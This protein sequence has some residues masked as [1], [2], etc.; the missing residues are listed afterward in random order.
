MVI[1]L[2]G[3][4]SYE[5]Q[6]VLNG[7]I[8]DFIDTYGDFGIERLDGEEA[9]FNRLQEAVTSLPFLTDKK[10]V[11]LHAPSKNKPFL[12]KAVETLK[13]AAI[14]SDII[15][16]EPKLDKRLAYYKFL[17]TNTDFRIYDT[18]D[19]NSLAQWLVAAAKERS[20]TLSLSDARYLVERVG[21]NQQ[22]V[23]SELEKLLLFSA[24]ISQQTIDLLTEETPQSTIFQLLE[25]AFAGN[26]RRALELYDEQRAMKVEPPQIIAML[27]WQLHI[28]AIII[29]AR[30]TPLDQI[31]RDTKINPY[32]LRKSFGIARQL[33]FS[34]LKLLISELLTIDL[35]LKSEPIDPDEI[36][37][38]YLFLLNNVDK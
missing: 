19:Q 8:V 26:T 17:K 1:T 35:R 25:A 9:D 4:N 37:K 27:A 11:V 20:G 23:F 15:I 30:N 16:V 2:T 32:V 5:L 31:A 34:S 24:Q 33:S 10:L 29:A 7:I 3:D 13:A 36:L 6:R 21:I 12:E 22:L 18:M 14:E 38:N 28:L